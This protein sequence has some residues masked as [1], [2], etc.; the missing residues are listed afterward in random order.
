VPTRMDRRTFLEFL[1]A[2]TAA[3][4]AP[5]AAASENLLQRSVAAGR[6]GRRVAVLG[7]GLAGLAAA[8]NLVKHGYDVVV[9]EAQHRP[10][11]RVLTLRD[12]F[13][14]NGYAEMGAIRIF[15]THTYTR[16]YVAEFKLPLVPIM[17]VG[18]RGYYMQGRRFLEPVAGAPW[19][20]DGF[21][22][23]EVPDPAA[24]FPE[25]VESGFKK[26]G[27]MFDPSWPERFDTA[28]SLDPFTLG[29]YIAAQGASETWR[30]WFFAREGNINRMNALAAFTVESLSEHKAVAAIRGGNDML[31]KAFAAA[32]GD[33]VKYGS[34]VVRLT[35]RPDGVS[36]GFLNQTQLHEIEA[37]RCV[38]ALPFAPLRSVMIPNPFSAPKM[39]AIHRLN[40]MAAARCY[41]QTASQFWTRDP[42]GELAD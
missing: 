20:L 39:A 19:P 42:L 16:K 23:S 3:H 40:Y 30:R 36:I 4:A 15:D 18:R 13:E 29:E 21:H 27:D 5:D 9:L 12:G 26:V 28:L 7:A 24:R 31:P 32:L 2:V 37:D 11:G 14:D 38:C 8:Y 6:G 25:Y 34:P 1:T 33:R 10:G 22:A 17:D 35:Q 41:F